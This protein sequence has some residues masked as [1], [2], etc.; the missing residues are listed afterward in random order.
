MQ[1][2]DHTFYVAA[3]GNNAWSGHLAEPNVQQSDGP[4]ATLAVA[5]AAARQQRVRD[6][7]NQRIVLRGGAYHNVALVLDAQDNGLTIEAAPGEQPILYGGQPITGWELDGQWWSAPLP[8][9]SDRMWDFRMLLVNNRLCPRARLPQV[10]GYT[11]RNQ[12]AVSWMSSTKGGWERAPTHEELTTLH[13][14]AG[15]L[16]SWFNCNNAEIT[17]YHAWD[18]STVGVASIDT[19]ARIVR[20]SNP[21]YHPAGAFAD[22]SPHA[23]TYTVWN[24]REGMHEPGQWYLDRTRGRVVYWP[25]VSEEMA[26]AEV[27][28]PTTEV[29]VKLVGQPETPVNGV[30]VRG[31]TLSVANTP[32][33]AA[34]FAAALLDGAV[35][36]NGPITDCQFLDLAIQNV[37][38]HGIKLSGDGVARIRIEGCT[39]DTTGAGGIWLWGSDSIITQNTLRDIGM[40]YTSAIAIRFGGERVEV[41]HN[42][43]RATSYSGIACGHIEVNP[44]PVIDAAYGGASGT[45]SK[46]HR[47]EYNNISC[48][49]Q[50]LHD[51]AAIYTIF[52]TG[53]TIRGNVVDDISGGGNRHAYYLDEQTEQSVVE[54]NLAVGVWPSQNHLA[55]NNVLRGNIFVCPGNAKLTF[56][57]SSCYIF[58]QNVVYATG[59]IQIVGVDAVTHWHDNL[60][61]SAQGTVATMRDDTTSAADSITP[62]I[63]SNTIL[64]NPLF[65]DLDNGDYRFQPESLAHTLGIAA[66]D[67]QRAGR[68]QGNDATPDA[69]PIPSNNANEHVEQRNVYAR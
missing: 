2:T 57:R 24:T 39:T 52:S 41:S 26:R 47:I 19:E 50:T 49:L 55:H 28:A 32:L 15:D 9:M 38:G 22:W 20:F 51:G 63:L 27:I 16:G 34:D 37:A 45:Y 30:T 61:Y 17:L 53:I 11:H 7:Q 46:R 64:F 42:D 8:E 59:T 4:Y 58:E 40:M 5:Q 25:L 23:Q 54:G 60:V 44:N 10:G 48:V 13:Y 35:T 66:I 3:N 6:G 67:V 36:G 21:A 68:T 33:I 12:F 62:D 18:D 31:L 1:S 29:I 65:V 14:Q 69:R 56:P 43:I